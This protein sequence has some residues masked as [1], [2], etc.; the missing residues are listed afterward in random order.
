MVLPSVSA[1][2]FVSVTPSM[3]IFFPILNPIFNDGFLSTSL[4]AHHPPEAVAKKQTCLKM[5]LW[6]SSHLCCR[7]ISSSVHRL[8][9]AAQSTHKY[10]TEA[11]A[12]QFSRVRIA[13]MNQHPWHYL[14]ETARP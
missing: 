7:K 6:C 2:N 5:V 1:L 3:G 11:P 8:A 13:N 14:A 4:L 12:V 9:V 10:F